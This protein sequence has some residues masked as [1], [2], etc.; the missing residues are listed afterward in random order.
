MFSR[1]AIPALRAASKRAFSTQAA[2]AGNASARRYMGAA[3]L[4]AGSALTYS[5]FSAPTVQLEGAKTIAGE[6]GTATERSYVMIKPD[7]TS[8][9][10]VGEVISRFEKRGYKLVALKSLIP[11]EALAKEHYVDLAKKPFYAG[12]VSYITCGT[13]VIA[14]VWEGKDVIR[15]GRRLVGATNPL[16]A[17]PGSI[18]GDYCVSVG[19]NII[20]ASDSHESATKEIGLWFDERELATEYK[21]IAWNMIMADN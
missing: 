9:Q 3:A 12:L 17:A 18:R 15:Q 6:L 8:R 4:V 21:P 11:S 7:G 19:R 20:H 2:S 16:D 14:M 13:P 10:I 1:T 5:A